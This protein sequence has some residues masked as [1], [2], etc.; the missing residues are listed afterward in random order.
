MTAFPLNARDVIPRPTSADAFSSNC[1]KAR[2]RDA[3]DAAGRSSC[4]A[5]RARE[6]G[7]NP[8]LVDFAVTACDRL[9]IGADGLPGQSLFERSD[10]HASGRGGV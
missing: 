8:Q 9:G 1:A 3:R 5:L 10:G 2:R 4:P 6:H 7:P